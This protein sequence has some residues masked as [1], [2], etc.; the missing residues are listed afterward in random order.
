MAGGEMD[1]GEEDWR[2][3][4]LEEWEM[5]MWWQFSFRDVVLSRLLQPISADCKIWIM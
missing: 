3:G 1:G 2:R 5:K 4:G